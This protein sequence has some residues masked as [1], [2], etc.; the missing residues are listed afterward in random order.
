[1]NLQGK[2]C[3]VTGGVRGIGGATAV[4][5]ARLGADIAVQSRDAHSGAAREVKASIEALGRRCVSIAADMAIPA[6]A[7]RTVEETVAGLGTIDVLVHNAGAA[8]PGSLLQVTDEVWYHAFNV[9]VHAA[10][11]LCRAAIPHMIPKKEGAIILLGSTAGH[12]GVL[13]AAA[14][15]IV[16]GAIPQFTRVLAREMADHNIR[17]NCVSPGVVRTRFQD[18]LTEAQVKNNLENRIPLHREGTSGEIAQ[19]IEMLATND[20]MTGSDVVIDGGLTMRMA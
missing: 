8:A 16:K 13:G 3:L 19:V 12:R 11:H 10:F 15:A 5:L 18:M 7:T 4:R 20:F 2:V 1:M 9:H 6:D 17:V 14:Y